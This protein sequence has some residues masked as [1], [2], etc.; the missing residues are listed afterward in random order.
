MYHSALGMKTDLSSTEQY[1]DERQWRLPLSFQ[2]I[3]VIPL[4]ALIFIFPESPR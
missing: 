2:L 4:A 3:P 1:T